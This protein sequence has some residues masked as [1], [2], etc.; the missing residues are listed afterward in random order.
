MYYLGLEDVLRKEYCKYYI[1]LEEALKNNNLDS[2]EI[3]VYKINIQENTPLIYHTNIIFY[4]NFNK[5]LPEGMHE[6][7][8]VLLRNSMYEFEK[9]KEED[10][11]TNMYF[12]NQESSKIRKVVIHE[13]N[14]KDK[15]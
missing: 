8:T 7:K 15:N 4:D 10:F 13:Y 11:K 3:Q 1:N 12:E 5:T 14:I 6:D 2:N 9:V